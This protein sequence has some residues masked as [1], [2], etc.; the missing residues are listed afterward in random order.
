MA[1]EDGQKRR[2]LEIAY[3]W[4]R[5]T[6]VWRPIAYALAA[7]VLHPLAEPVEQLPGAYVGGLPMAVEE[8]GPDGLDERG[9]VVAPYCMPHDVADTFFELLHVGASL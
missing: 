1:A 6:W 9:R 7:E 4:L 3:G 5:D 8:T 2:V